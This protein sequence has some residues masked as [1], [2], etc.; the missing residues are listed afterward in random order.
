M[1]SE[2]MLRG[3]GPQRQS[4]P[5]HA[6]CRTLSHLGKKTSPSGNN[7]RQKTTGVA[8]GLVIG[9]LVLLLGGTGR[10]QSGLTMAVHAT[11]FSAPL[12]IVQDP[13]NRGV[14]FVV[15]QGGRIGVAQSG[16]R[17]GTECL[18]LSGAVRPGGGRGVHG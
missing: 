13:T 3:F 12:A 14:Q 18:T 16:T 1:A 10:T 11:G 17:L 15:E 4:L 9:V 7:M 2:L 8:I 6:S 5:L